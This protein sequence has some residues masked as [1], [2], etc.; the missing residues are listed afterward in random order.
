M[1]KVDKKTR[2]SLCMTGNFHRNS[3]VNRLYLKLRQVEED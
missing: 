3:D 1:K 2:R